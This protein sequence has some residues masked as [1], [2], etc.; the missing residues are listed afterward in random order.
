MET[1]KRLIW[2]LCMAIYL[3]AVQC[4]DEE[5]ITYIISDR[6]GR[7]GQESVMTQKEFYKRETIL[8]QCKTQIMAVWET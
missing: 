8:L 6:P 1:R 3:G 2:K 5:M 7:K 4:D